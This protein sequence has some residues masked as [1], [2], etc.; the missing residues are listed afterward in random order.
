M[1]QVFDVDRSMSVLGDKEKIRAMFGLDPVTLSG[2]FERIV[3]NASNEKVTRTGI[4]EHLKSYMEILF[5]KYL[6]KITNP[7]FGTEH[8]EV[9]TF[10]SE[11]AKEI[12]LRG[13]VLDSV[14]GFGEGVRND[15]IAR[16]R[17]EAMTK[18][19]WGKYGS[20]MSAI[21][22][23]IRDVPLMSILTVHIDRAEGEYGETLEFPGI[24]G[25]QKTDSL[26][27]FDVIV[28]THVDED[29]AVW[30]Q[31]AKSPS[32]PWIR[33]RA[34]VPEWEGQTFVEQDFMPVLRAYKGAPTPLKMLIA[35]DSGT[36]KT[37]S[38]RTLAPY[39]EAVRKH[40]SKKQKQQDK[41]DDQ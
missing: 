39:V 15:L 11:K 12:G 17:F 21:L 6:V 38:L 5:V 24:K 33:S 18:D 29:G 31:V 16:H 32:R 26:R 20:R 25:G 27:W 2:D 14:S 41:E 8:E 23:A 34:P 10:L 40:A 1:I 36:G 37:T 28:Y 9:R 35:G 30:W 19:L 13:I 22:T 4:D 7:V 3:T